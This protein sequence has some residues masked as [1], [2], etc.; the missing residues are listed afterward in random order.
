MRHTRGKTVP[1]SLG[2]NSELHITPLA[3]DDLQDID[4]YTMEHWGI[5]QSA[6]LEARIWKALWSIRDFPFIG[7]PIGHR[8]SMQRALYVEGFRVLYLLD[9]NLVTILRIQHY[10]IESPKR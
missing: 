3:L 6:E 7:R 1:E 8:H 10:R 4:L 5:E 9:R 2:G